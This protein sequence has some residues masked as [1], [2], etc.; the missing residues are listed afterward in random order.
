[1]KLAELKR[2]PSMAWVGARGASRF[3][4]A[5]LAGDVASPE[6]REVRRAICR[7]CP[8]RVRAK[9]FGAKS[10][11]DWCGALLQRQAPSSNCASCEGAKTCGCLL[12]GKT[13]VAS[14]ECPLGKW[15]AEQ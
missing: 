8:E 9:L 2:L 14:E 7:E 4:L 5:I 11:S 15:S 1:M 12:A 6:D 13:M 10:E 3:A